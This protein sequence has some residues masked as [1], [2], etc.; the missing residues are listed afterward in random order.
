MEQKIGELE[1]YKTAFENKVVDLTVQLSEVS[2]QFDHHKQRHAKMLQSLDE[3]V[4]SANAKQ[5][6]IDQLQNR[7]EQLQEELAIAQV[8]VRLSVIL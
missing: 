5:H 7:I 4:K 6:K 2:G 1:M 3:S 8:Q